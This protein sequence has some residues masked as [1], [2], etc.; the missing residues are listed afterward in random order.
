MYLSS[1]KRL[2]KDP[3]SLRSGH[4]KVAARLKSMTDLITVESWQKYVDDK[5]FTMELTDAKQTKKW[6]EFKT[7]SPVKTQLLSTTANGYTSPA[8]GYPIQY[9]DMQGSYYP[10][11]VMSSP[12]GY[13]YVYGNYMQSPPY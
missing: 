2:R 8:Q 13:S 5:K 7:K 6:K 12:Q 10:Y 4:E 1:S 11:Y 3:I 9:T